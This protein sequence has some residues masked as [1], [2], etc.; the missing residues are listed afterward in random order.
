MSGSVFSGLQ[1]SFTIIPISSQMRNIMPYFK[2]FYLEN[3]IY[4]EMTLIVVP[5]ELTVTQI[6]NSLLPNSELNWRKY[7]KPLDHSGMT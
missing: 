7:G 5:T 3:E 2:K 1:N 4:L 6:M